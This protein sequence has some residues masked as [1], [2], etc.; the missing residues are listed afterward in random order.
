MYTILGYKIYDS[1]YPQM[2]IIDTPKF[3][4][5][6]VQE[7]DVYDLYEYLSQEKVVKHLPFSAHKNLDET[8]KFIQSFFI[9]NYKKGKVGNYAIYHKKDR[10]VIGNIG[11]NNVSPK[12]NDCKIGI[13]LNPKYWG[14]D[15][16]TELTVLVLITGFELMNL[17]KLIAITYSENKYSSKCLYN[18]GFKYIKTYKPQKSIPLSHRFEL[19]KDEYFE[20]KKEFFPNLIKQFKNK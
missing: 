15:Y 14:N 8:Q 6:P 3:V 12:S 16:S 19:T 13:C 5:R 18:T 20:L 2:K 11:I 1:T 7:S 17:N 4:L 9:N 10:K